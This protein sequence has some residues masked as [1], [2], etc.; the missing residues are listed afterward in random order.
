MH[1]TLHRPSDSSESNLVTARLA[2]FLPSTPGRSNPF[3]W[4][5]NA[6]SHFRVS[7][8][9]STPKPI[10]SLQHGT[11]CHHVLLSRPAAISY[12]K[13]ATDAN[14]G[15]R[16][17][18]LVYMCQPHASSSRNPDGADNDITCFRVKI[19]PKLIVFVLAFSSLTYGGHH[20][21]GVCHYQIQIAM[22]HS[23]LPCYK[24]I[25]LASDWFRNLLNLRFTA[26]VLYHDWSCHPLLFFNRVATTPA[27]LHD[28]CIAAGV[29]CGSHVESSSRISL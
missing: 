14:K 26:P 24:N 21:N 4:K 29:Q 1:L 27:G 18:L 15:R 2:T 28:M 10:S 9:C 19:G 22:T 17:G 8:V 13:D 3:S 6:C 12:L 5:R 16:T 25:L 7:R 11:V 23:A 20:L